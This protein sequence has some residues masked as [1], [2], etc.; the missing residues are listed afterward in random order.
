MKIVHTIEHGLDETQAR[1]LLE[2]A[3]NDYAARYA[4]WK[5]WLRWASEHEAEAGFEALGRKLS[6]RLRLRPG[7][8]EIEAEVPW[9]MRPFL[10]RARAVVD[11]E[12]AR[13]LAEAPASNR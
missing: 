3:W 6:G 9:P 7:R 4:R 5:P 13:W 10:P 12:A 1:Q 11:R 8:L 2:R